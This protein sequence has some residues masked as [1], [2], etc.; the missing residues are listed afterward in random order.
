[1]T[2]LQ[3]HIVSTDVLGDTTSLTSNHIGIADMVEQRCLTVVDVSHHCYDRSATDQIVLI[4][5]LLCNGVLNLSRN[6][7]G[8]KAKLVSHDVDGLSIQTLV[9]RHHDTNRHAGTDNL[10]NSY[11]HHGSQL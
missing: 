5:L 9:D 3:L 6:I 8:S 4:V 1:M 11:I 10:V 7:F 2:I